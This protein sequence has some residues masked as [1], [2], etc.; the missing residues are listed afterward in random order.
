[1]EVKQRTYP[2]VP[3]DKGHFGVFGGRYIPETLLPAS[4]ELDRCY[5]KLKN[6]D[7]FQKE[8]Q[9]YLKYFVGRETP[10]FFAE[11]LTKYANIS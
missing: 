5:K 2:H 6:D 9:Y 8:F 3:D 10:L 11:R 1:M 4:E 7:E